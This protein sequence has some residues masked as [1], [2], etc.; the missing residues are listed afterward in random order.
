MK[1]TLCGQPHI[2]AL[3]LGLS[4]E[5]LRLAKATSP[6]EATL[7][8]VWVSQCE[9]EL[10]GELQFLGMPPDTLKDLDDDQ[11]LKELDL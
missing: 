1:V 11:L 9:K 3:R 7:R 6:A 2:D 8:R 4:N 10:A 5:R